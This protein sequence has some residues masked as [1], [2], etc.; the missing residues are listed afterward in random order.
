VHYYHEQR[1][2]VDEVEVEWNQVDAEAPASLRGTCSRVSL[3]LT[4]NPNPYLNPDA[5]SKE[6]ET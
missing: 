6:P 2:Y 3:T 4:L 1:K 5:V